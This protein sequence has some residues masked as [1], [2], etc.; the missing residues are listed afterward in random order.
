MFKHNTFWGKY[1]PFDD[2]SNYCTKN[3]N[4]RKN[5]VLHGFLFK[6]VVFNYILHIF[7]YFFIIK[8][9]GSFRMLYCT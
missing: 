2:A 1:V 5:K 7:Y 3:V 6:T 9:Q 8:V 4:Y